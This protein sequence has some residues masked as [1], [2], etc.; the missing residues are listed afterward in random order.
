MT[1][2]GR[3]FVCRNLISQWAEEKSGY[4]IVVRIAWGKFSTSPVL[5][6]PIVPIRKHCSRL[7]FPG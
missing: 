2:I 1:H 6:R 3:K 4:V 7:N 5:K